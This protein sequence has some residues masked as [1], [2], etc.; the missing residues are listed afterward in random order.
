M[1]ECFCLNSIGWEICSVYTTRFSWNSI[2]KVE[3]SV[4]VVGIVNVA[5]NLMI[6]SVDSETGG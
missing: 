4:M 6:I 2:C 5:L 3:Y 1:H